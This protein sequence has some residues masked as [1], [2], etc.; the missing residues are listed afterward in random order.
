LEVIQGA[1]VIE[2][3]G[4]RYL[5]LKSISKLASK[6]TGAVDAFAEAAQ[7]AAAQERLQANAPE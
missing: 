2:R 7:V 1:D 4:A 6:E 3:D 5:D